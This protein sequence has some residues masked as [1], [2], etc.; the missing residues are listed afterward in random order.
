MV[1]TAIYCP[2]LYELRESTATIAV[3]YGEVIKLLG[4]ARIMGGSV[5]MHLPLAGMIRPNDF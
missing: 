5:E 1:L 4:D 2:C 3:K